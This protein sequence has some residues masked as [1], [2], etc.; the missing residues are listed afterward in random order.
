MNGT[1]IGIDPMRTRFPR[2]PAQMH[3]QGNDGLV[4]LVDRIQVLANRRT[5][6]FWSSAVVRRRRLLS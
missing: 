3:M 5:V 4:K 1:N 2:A 6:A